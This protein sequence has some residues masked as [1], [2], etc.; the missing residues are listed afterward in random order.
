MA[1]VLRGE[2]LIQAAA[3]ASAGGRTAAGMHSLLLGAHCKP[4]LLHHASAFPASAECSA[5]AACW[6]PGMPASGL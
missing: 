6:G 4:D 5:A 2:A 3:A 1:A